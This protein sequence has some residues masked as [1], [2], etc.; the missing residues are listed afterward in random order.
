MLSRGKRE[1]SSVL[2]VFKSS[3]CKL[4]GE[5]L[6]RKKK[7]T[8]VSLPRWGKKRM[9]QGT[10]DVWPGRRMTYIAI[11]RWREFSGTNRVYTGTRTDRFA[12]FFFF[13]FNGFLLHLTWH[14]RWLVC[15]NYFFFFFIECGRR[16]C[17]FYSFFINVLRVDFSLSFFLF[18]IHDI[19][20]FTAGN[21]VE[22]FFQL[23][24]FNL[25]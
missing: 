7:C 24:C 13:F 6:P 17:F 14:L 12:L 8:V 3:E 22:M 25:D 1:T 4:L 5:I 23:E 11:P 15:T 18:F 9:G 16:W 19:E 21:S 20:A 10:H 2:F